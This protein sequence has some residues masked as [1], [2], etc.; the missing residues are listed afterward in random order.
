[1][2]LPKTKIGDI[3]ISR[4]IIG[5]NTF[6]GFSHFSHAKDNWLK[7][8][9][10]HDKKYELIE[11]CANLGMNA[12]LSGTNDEFYEILQEIERN[13][14]HHIVWICTPGGR[15]AKDLEPGIKWCADHGVEICMPH[16]MFTDNNMIPAQNRIEGA[17]EVLALIRSQGM[18]TGWSTHRP[19]AIV[20]SD[21]A[22]YDI[23]AYIQPYNSIGFLCSVET[24]WVGQVI[25]RTPKPV[26]CI[27]P[28]GAGRIMPPTG[29][30]FVYNSIKPIDTV[31]IGMMGPQEAE[32]DAR[33]AL[34]IMEK[35]EAGVQLQY[36]RSKQVLEG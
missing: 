35:I 2:E 21:A 31:C 11:A 7:Q 24:D 28:L 5:S 18:N 34:S 9:F 6:H 14:G 33:I 16:Q 30:G 20:V 17:E 22:G 23:D 15:V 19:E 8:Y 3:E 4:M 26:I 10:T 32:E 1:M 29:L 27:K 36:T 13:T 25:R 12:V